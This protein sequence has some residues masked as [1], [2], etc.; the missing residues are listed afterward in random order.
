LNIIYN[1]YKIENVDKPIALFYFV[2]E[3]KIWGKIKV[4]EVTDKK[5]CSAKKVK[6]FCMVG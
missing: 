5:F 1:N 4:N 3:N 6:T 2:K